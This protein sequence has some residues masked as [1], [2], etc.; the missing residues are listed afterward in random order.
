MSDYNGEIAKERLKSL[1]E[2][3]ERLEEEKKAIQSDIR[4]IFAESKSAGFD[5]K[6]MRQILKLRRMNAADRDNQ[7]YLL[8]L[9][10]KALDL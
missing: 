8:D 7:E 2:R 4:D 9:Y 6:V 3:I 1:I 5:T 10:K